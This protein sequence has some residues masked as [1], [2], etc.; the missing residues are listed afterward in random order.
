MMISLKDNTLAGNS[1]PYLS[2]I[3]FSCF[4]FIVTK[5]LVLS[6]LKIMQNNEVPNLI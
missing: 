5:L 1:I 3:I 2:I 6:I 4:V